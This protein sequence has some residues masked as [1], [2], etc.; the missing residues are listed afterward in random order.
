MT[1]K[2]RIQQHS[3]TKPAT[4]M[5]AEQVKEITRVAVITLACAV[6]AP[7]ERMHWVPV[8]TA[9]E[10]SSFSCCRKGAR[11]WLKGNFMHTRS[12]GCITA[13]V[14]WIKRQRSMC[15]RLKS[16]TEPRIWKIDKLQAEVGGFERNGI[17]IWA[18]KETRKKKE[19]KKTRR[20]REV[21]KI[22]S[23]RFNLFF[24]EHLKLKSD[25]KPG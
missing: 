20:Y 8:W 21:W 24:F 5:N 11:H 18:E 10:A 16:Q 15:G 6:A 23:H 3:T 13:G 25:L 7:A 19:N 14:Q 4:E 22:T 12:F 17:K 9:L 2:S 1:H